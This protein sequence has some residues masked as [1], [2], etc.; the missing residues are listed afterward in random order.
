M[1]IVC[2]MITIFNPI[3]AVKRQKTQSW[4]KGNNREAIGEEQLPKSHNSMH[5]SVFHEALNPSFLGRNEDCNVAASLTA[6][7]CLLPCSGQCAGTS[8]AGLGPALPMGGVRTMGSCPCLCLLLPHAALLQPASCSMCTAWSNYAY[9][10]HGFLP[11]IRF[12]LIIIAKAALQG[13]TLA[14]GLFWHYY[15]SEN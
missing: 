9:W 6:R 4:Q 11:R 14:F 13:S 7:L 2:I 8:G 12:L 10:W 3:P 15:L 5:D 1:L